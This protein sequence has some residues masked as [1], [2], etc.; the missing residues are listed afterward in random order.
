MKYT[1]HMTTKNTPQSQ[2]IMGMNQVKN[3]A[4]GYAFPVSDQVGLER[5]LTLGSE[6]GTFYV[7]EQKLT[8]DNAKSIIQMIEKN[9]VDVVD[10]VAKFTSSGRALKQD[11][12]LFVLALACTW[13]NLQTRQAAYKAISNVARTS[14]H[15]FTFCQMIQDLR[16]WS[17]G[18]R[19]AVNRWYEAKD[20][21]QLAYQLVKYR[22]RNGWT[23]R[24]V[25]RL[26]HPKPDTEARAYMYR[27]AVGKPV[28]TNAEHLPDIIGAFELAQNT[29]NV[30]ELVSLIQ[31][32]GLTWE[33]IPTEMLN[34]AKVLE[35][36]LYH[37][38]PATAMLRNLNRFAIVGL[39]KERTNAATKFITNVITNRESLKHGHVHP[40]TILNTLKVYG[41]GHGHR[42]GQSW[43]PNQ[44][45]VDALAEAFELS[46]EYM[47]PTGKKILVAV[48]VSG[49][50]QDSISNMALTCA[51]ASAA[52]LM[53]FLRT[54]PNVEPL[55][56]DTDAHTP[57]I[58]KRSSYKEVLADSH[59]RG[60]TDC[61]VPYNYASRKGLHF[62]SIVTLT[63][64][65]TW[66]GSNHP[67]Q[68]Y[69]QYKKAINPDV[70]TAVVGMT[71]TDFSIFP[72]EDTNALNVAGFD[73]GVPTLIN[74]FIRE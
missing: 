46:F 23:H 5:F 64:S 25:L 27:Y 3:N 4:G 60:G 72:A 68:A 56:F 38:M 55:Y 63:D 65:E 14:T 50:M 59:A 39:T 42:G 62:D 71:A 69:K 33:M 22:Q 18:L 43:T 32:Y 61:S 57:K 30:L 31:K 53:T 47:I 19:N 51:E 1:K 15:L 49:S 24:D 17:R 67:V 9:G 41:S 7:S 12:S 73:A 45:I 36:L 28:D 54:E 40:I 58:G 6:G 2:P 21:D 8:Q 10:T 35:A 70:K 29:T 48:D 20:N 52:L 34:H 66:Y 44:A 16:G 26:A 13:G 11:P 74:N 37:Q